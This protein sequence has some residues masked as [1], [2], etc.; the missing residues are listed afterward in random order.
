MNALLQREMK[1]EKDSHSTINHLLSRVQTDWVKCSVI[2]KFLTC[3]IFH[4]RNKLATA[5]LQRI[6]QFWMSL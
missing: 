6:M 1:K 5:F 3:S 4:M 2:E